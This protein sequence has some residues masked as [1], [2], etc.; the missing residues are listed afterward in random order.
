[1]KIK[2]RSHRVDGEGDLTPMIDMVFQLVA[3]FM[4]LINFSQVEQA[5]VIKLPYS[6]LVKPPEEAR[7]NILTLQIK[8]DGNVI[9]GGETVEMEGTE[10]K[11]RQEIGAIR[12]KKMKPSE[13][14]VI[15]RADGS[16]KHG[17]VQRLVEICQGVQFQH[18]ALRATQ[19]KPKAKKKA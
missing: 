14:V 6:E 3:F 12:E 15:I 1:M 2:P 9:L 17:D 5:E 13:T 19:E 10:R 4:V 11:L 16:A 18:F 7:E 8:K